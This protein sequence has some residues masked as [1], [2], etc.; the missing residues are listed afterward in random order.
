MS[1]V[2]E[3]CNIDNL[4][5]VIGIRTHVPQL[6]QQFPAFPDPFGSYDDMQSKIQ[7]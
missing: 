1:D 4:A 3:A 5:T 7:K 2:P 6:G